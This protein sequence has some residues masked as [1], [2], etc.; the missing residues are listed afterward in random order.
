MFKLCK[1]K[2]AIHVQNRKFSLSMKQII[3][4]FNIQTENV[5]T[6]DESPFYWEYLP[7]KM[8]CNQYW[9]KTQATKAV[10]TYENYDGNGESEEV[11]VDPNLV[12]VE[13]EYSNE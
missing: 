12:D 3:K 13:F 5:I 4:R 9:S 7:K 8:I 6:L 11:E 10:T 1:L 2:R